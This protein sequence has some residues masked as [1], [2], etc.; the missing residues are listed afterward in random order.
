M[1]EDLSFKYIHEE[2]KKGNY[3]TVAR[4][5]VKSLKSQDPS[6]D[7]RI[8]FLYIST[9]KDW[10]LLKATVQ[11]YTN[12]TGKD[13]S[14]YWNAIYLFMERALVFGESDLVIRYG[15]QF[16]KD[17]KSNARYPDALFMLSY[18][19]SDLKNDSEASKI[20]EELEKQNLTVKL[21]SQIAEFKSELKQSG[22]Q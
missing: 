16:Q 1:A 7:P 10:N 13:S 5:A 14:F 12:P 19:L 20:L 4:L 9:E 8:F 11:S 15:R 2:Y 6:K 18:S 22:A 3:E 17:G 21:Q